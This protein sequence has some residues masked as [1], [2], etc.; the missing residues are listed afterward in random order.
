MIQ[1]RHKIC[2]D[3][4]HGDWLHFI[5]DPARRDHDRQTFSQIA[6][7]LEGSRAGADDGTGAELGGGKCLAQ[8]RSNLCA[9]LQVRGSLVT[10]WQEPAKVD[11]M[12]DAL[13]G[14]D[15]VAYGS[16]V[17]FGVAGA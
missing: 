6:H 15:E 3:V 12:G 4:A 11:D 10:L 7:H 1:C 9:A 16:A 5:D 8:Q 13:R 14:L 17:L 2:Q